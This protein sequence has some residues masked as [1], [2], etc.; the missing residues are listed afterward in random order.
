MNLPSVPAIHAKIEKAIAARPATMD[1]MK[2]IFCS[3]M[4]PVYAAPLPRESVIQYEP[5]YHASQQYISKKLTRYLPE[6]VY[7]SIDGTVTT[8]AIIAGIAGARL[9]ASIVI[10]L[11]FSNVLADGF[12]MASSNYLSEQSHQDQNPDSDHAH[13]PMK[14]AIATLVSFVVIGSIPVIA[15]I[16]ATILPRLQSHAFL[17]ASICT[18][19][20]FLAIGAIRGMTAGK[21]P[22]RTA[23]ETFAIGAVAAGV[24][25][26]VGA[27]LERVL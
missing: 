24:A 9:D 17:F 16:L 26:A 14:T 11:G 10:I 13:T 20:T 4:V 12:S 21:H 19:I 18:G 6:F 23:L 22:V 25:Y 27:F 7:G 2:N 15:Y 1:T 8:F 3:V 5:M